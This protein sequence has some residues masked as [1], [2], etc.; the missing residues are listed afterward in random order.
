MKLDLREILDV[1]GARLP[2]ERELDTAQLEFPSVLKY[3]GPVK[4]A[5][6]IMNTA[7]V[8]TAAGGIDADMLCVCDRCGREFELA[9]HV[10]VDA[11]VVPEDEG[12]GEE[13]DAFPLE[14][15]WL[16]IDGL[17]ETVFILDMD[18]KFLCKPDCKGLCPKCGKNLNDG[19]CSCRPDA[20][21]RFAV[22]EQLL[23]K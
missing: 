23:D 11:P 7:G 20:D 13:G 22:L 1:P 6:E 5:G 3:L 8:L 16:D 9:R 4:A 10:A 14:G 2:F 21:P 15:D 18:T 19:E 12:E 17:L